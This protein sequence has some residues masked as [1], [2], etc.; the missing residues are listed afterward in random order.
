MFDN[1]DFWKAVVCITAFTCITVVAIETGNLKVLWWY[2]VPL[3]MW[4]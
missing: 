4:G 2:I 1:E 3:L